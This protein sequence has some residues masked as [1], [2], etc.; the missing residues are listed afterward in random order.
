MRRLRAVEPGEQPDQAAREVA[1]AALTLAQGIALL[2]IAIGM[3]ALAV[4][5]VMAGPWIGA[6][7]ARRPGARLL[8]RTMGMRD[9]ALGAGALL[10]LTRDE[11]ARN[12]IVMGAL[13]DAMDATITAAAFQ[14]LPRWGRWGVLG[15]AGGAALAGM[16]AAARIGR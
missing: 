13:S 5:Q 10:A 15:S 11:D 4:P 16:W 12:W 14:K 3:T 2:R 7:E 1:L 9:V 8:A 6:S